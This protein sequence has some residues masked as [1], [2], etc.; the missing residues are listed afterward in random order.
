MLAKGVTLRPDT[1]H[2]LRRGWCPGDGEWGAG[3]HQLIQL[4]MP[5]G[6]AVR[7]ATRRCVLSESAGCKRSEYADG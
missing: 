3:C 6:I 1:L 2:T 5:D 7:G 4:W